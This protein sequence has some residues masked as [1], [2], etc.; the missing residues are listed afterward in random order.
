MA[1]ARQRESS[2]SS[3]MATARVRA[4]PRTMTTASTT[5]SRGSLKLVDPIEKLGRVAGCDRARRARVDKTT[6]FS[7]WR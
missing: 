5:P 4:R 1:V 3:R 6:R 7:R 2:P